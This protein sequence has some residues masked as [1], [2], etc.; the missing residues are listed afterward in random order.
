MVIFSYLDFSHKTCN[1]ENIQL[2]VGSGQWNLESFSVNLCTENLVLFF[3]E[4]RLCGH[5]R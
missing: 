4:K 3:E 2:L 1:M 5:H